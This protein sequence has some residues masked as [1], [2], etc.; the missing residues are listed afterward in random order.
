MKAQDLKK[1]RVNPASHTGRS[2]VCVE[3]FRKKLVSNHS[4]AGWLTFFPKSVSLIPKLNQIE[5]NYADNM[6]LKNDACVKQFEC[7]FNE[8]NVSDEDVVTIEKKYK[9]TE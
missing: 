2:T 1:S 4:Q 5:F 9:R 3:R 7:C 6:D 8:M